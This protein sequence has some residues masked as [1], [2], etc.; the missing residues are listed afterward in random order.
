MGLYNINVHDDPNSVYGSQLALKCV[1]IFTL[2]TCEHVANGDDVYNNDFP[3]VKGYLT[4]EYY[5]YSLSCYKLLNTS[6]HLDTFMNTNGHFW[7]EYRQGI[8]AIWT[9]QGLPSPDQTSYQMLGLDET[10]N[11]TKVSL[12]TYSLTF[13]HSLTHSPTH[14]PTKKQVKRAYYRQSLLWH[15]DRW[16]SYPNVYTIAVQGVFEMISDAYKK[17]IVNYDTN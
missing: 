9:G 5:L 16:S 1:D 14:S 17:V 8:D 10:K 7:V 15:P 11:L 12:R 2:A 3:K 6:W 13:T 4:P